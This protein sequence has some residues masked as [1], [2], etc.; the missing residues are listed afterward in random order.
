MEQ[1]VNA[2]SQ[3]RWAVD[4]QFKVWRSDQ[5]LYYKNKTHCLKEIVYLP[6]YY[7]IFIKNFALKLNQQIMYLHTI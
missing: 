7:F 2:I 4:S 6:S 1:S 5:A 3:R